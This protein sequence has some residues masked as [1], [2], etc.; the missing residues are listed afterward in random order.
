MEV[1]RVDNTAIVAA[2]QDLRE[3][4]VDEDLEILRRVRVT[5]CCAIVL[6]LKC[7]A[8]HAH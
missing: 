8:E 7:C 2:Q 5:L 4:A 1:N 3:S 6:P